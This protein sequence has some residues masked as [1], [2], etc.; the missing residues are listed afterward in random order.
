MKRAQSLFWVDRKLKIDML[1]VHSVG[2]KS[3]EVI[4]IFK[5]HKVS[6]HY[7]V[8]EDGEIWQLVA[9][10]YSAWHAGISK[11]RGNENIN[12]R[13]IGIE[14][15][16][17]SLGQK[18]FSDEQRKAGINLLKKLVKKYKIRPE[19]VV[20]HSDI[21]PMRKVDPG[22]S[23]FWKEISD[24]GIGLWYDINDAGKMNEDNINKLL[25]EIGYDVSNL[26]A[27]VYAFCRRFYPE[28]INEERDIMQMEKQ[29]F[30]DS[31]DII[32]DDKFLQ[33]LKAVTYKYRNASKTPCKM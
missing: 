31:V 26:D 2:F 19:N 8:G 6:S 29:P 12:A 33:I 18:P 23:F 32:C 3:E 27:A 11:W 20:G 14:F 16:S 15:C 4:D 17:S 22:K 28:K 13:S 7:I 24:E 5:K 21:A 1:V 25:E 10:K 9:R 30:G